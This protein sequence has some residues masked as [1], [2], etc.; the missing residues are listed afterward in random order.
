MDQIAVLLERTVVFDDNSNRNLV[1]TDETAD[2]AKIHVARILAFHLHRQSVPDTVDDEI[3]LADD[4]LVGDR[5]IERFVLVLA[6][7]VYF[8]EHEY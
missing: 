8:D 2:T 3:D 6:D 5:S 4:L 7:I 1:L